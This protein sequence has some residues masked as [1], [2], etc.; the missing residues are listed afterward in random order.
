MAVCALSWRAMGAH[1]VLH[2]QLCIIVIVH[3]TVKE[4]TPCSGFQRISMVDNVRSG[5]PTRT[6][7]HLLTK[8]P[9]HERA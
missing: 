9:V 3:P 5:N 8:Y 2:Y 4:A 6:T 1:P 7:C